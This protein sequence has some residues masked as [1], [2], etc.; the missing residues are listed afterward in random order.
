MRRLLIGTILA[1]FG[2]VGLLGMGYSAGP[3]PAAAIAQ[4]LG[5]C[6]QESEK[7]R[8]HDKRQKSRKTAE[9]KYKSKTKPGDHKATGNRT[10]T[11]AGTVTTGTT[12]GTP[13]TT[14]TGHRHAEKYRHT[15]TTDTGTTDD[16]GPPRGLAARDGCSSDRLAPLGIRYVELQPQLRSDVGNA[17]GSQRRLRGNRAESRTCSWH[18]HPWS[19]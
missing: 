7:E 1:M 10:G 6:A 18:G 3:S 11:P 12:T 14:G 9:A 16:E 19:V 15:G 4:K 17:D 5:Q 13:G 8:L 2:I